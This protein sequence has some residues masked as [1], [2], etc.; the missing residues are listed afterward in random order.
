MSEI[1]E[2]AELT[3]QLYKIIKFFGEKDLGEL[4]KISGLKRPNIYYYIGK[5]KE[6]EKFKEFILS[7]GELQEENNLDVKP[8]ENKDVKTTKNPYFLILKGL[9]IAGEMGAGIERIK[10][11]A[12]NYSNYMEVLNRLKKLGLIK[13]AG[14][15]TKTKKITEEGE[16]IY[17]KFAYDEHLEKFKEL[18]RS[19]LNGIESYN[20]KDEIWSNPYV[21]GFKVICEYGGIRSLKR[22]KELAEKIEKNTGYSYLE[23]IKTLYIMRLIQ[24]SSLIATNRGNKLYE[25]IKRFLE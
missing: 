9:G 10:R 24:M 5:F 15:H 21:I 7:V 2:K 8:E 13:D 22:Q 17:R 25:K 3:K 23:M 19:L 18:V 11:Y 20:Y 4:S 1:R 14:N 12:G 6:D 16:K